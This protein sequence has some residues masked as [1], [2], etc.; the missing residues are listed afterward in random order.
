M[1]RLVMLVAVFAC[2]G[3]LVGPAAAGAQKKK[4]KKTTLV[5]DVLLQEER[6]TFVDINQNGR[7]DPGDSFMG[8][9]DVF[10]RG[11][12]TRIG[13]V[14]FTN[15]VVSSRFALFSAA[16][17]LRDGD[18]YLEGLTNLTEEED[19][20]YDAIVG[21]TRAYKG[22]RGQAKERVIGEGDDTSAD[23][24]LIRVELS[25]KTLAKKKKNGNKR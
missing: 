1:K 5:V 17:R 24:V 10:R 14:T 15:L 9:I 3:L 6:L 7:P 11:T 13:S 4:E 2:A 12:R 18:L 22:A 8:T 23:D 25:F 19:V 21:G 20:T 16:V